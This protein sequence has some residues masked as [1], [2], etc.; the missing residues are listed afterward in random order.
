MDLG[1]TADMLGFFSHGLENQ[2]RVKSTPELR[3]HSTL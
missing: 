2:R 1:S 3:F